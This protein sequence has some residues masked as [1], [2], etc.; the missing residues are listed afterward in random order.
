MLGDSFRAGIEIDLNELQGTEIGIE[1][2]FGKKVDDVV[3]EPVF[4]EEMKM[5][6]STRTNLTFACEIPFNQAGVYDYTFRLF[7]KNELLPHRQDFPLVK[8]I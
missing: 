8:W 5:V 7:P 1:V 2:V 4:V 6:R 3:K